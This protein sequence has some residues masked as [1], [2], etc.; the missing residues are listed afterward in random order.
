MGT[1]FT[2]FM[3]V[4]TALTGAGTWLYL[5]RE[6]AREAGEAPA[7]R[8]RAAGAGTKAKRQ[9]LKDLW[10]VE[11]V[12]RGVLVLTGGRY[13]L[14][15]RVSAADFWLLSEAEQNE[16]EDAAAA[17]LLQLTFPVQVLVTSQAVDT[18][19]AVEELR[20]RAGGLP[21]GLREMAL[22]RAE[23]LEALTQERGALARQ[24]YLVVPYDTPKG[25]DHAYTEL[26]ARLAVL[27]SALAA[28]RVRLEPL[29]SEAVCDLLSH[30]LNRGRSWRPSEGVEVGVM[31][32][33]TVS[34]RS[35]A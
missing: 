21:E 24:A 23:Y 27:A 35:V 5:R 19:A 4:L 34:E 32:L 25:F 2:V 13:R 12:R 16:V 30:L 10:E 22:A 29:S 18:R 20:E 8:P 1:A 26:Q 14:L 31:S 17:A 9:N 6:A 28:A 15:C 7:S 11:D 3:L 33:Y